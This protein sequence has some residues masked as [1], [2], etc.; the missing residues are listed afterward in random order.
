MI[1]ILHNSEFLNY[2]RVKTVGLGDCVPVADVDTDDLDEAYSLTQNLH[3]NW[4]FNEGVARLGDAPGYRSTSVGDLMARG[5]SVYVVE[6][7][8]FRKLPGAVV[9]V[10]WADVNPVK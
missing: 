1:R 4:V 2:W 9:Y 7:A 6:E 8:G 10:P 5:D 3:R